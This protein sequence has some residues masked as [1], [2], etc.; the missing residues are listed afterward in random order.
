MSLKELAD[1]D[2]DSGSGD[3]IRDPDDVEDRREFLE[4]EEAKISAKLL[5]DT[6]V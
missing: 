5:N 3:E 1:S 6:M 2:A 4:S